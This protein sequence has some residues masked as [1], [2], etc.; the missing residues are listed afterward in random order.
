MGSLLKHREPL[1]VHIHISKNAH[2]ITVES[3]STT[4]T[5]NV[6]TQNIQHIGNLKHTV[7]MHSIKTNTTWLKL[8]Q[9]HVQNISLKFSKGAI[10]ICYQRIQKGE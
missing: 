5:N 4:P 1:K 7:E 9:T 3:E 6:I 2:L 8:L 10:T